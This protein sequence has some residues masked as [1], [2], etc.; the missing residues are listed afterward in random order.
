MTTPHRGLCRPGGRPGLFECH[1]HFMVDGDFSAKT[2]LESP[3]SPAFFQAAERMAH[4][5]DVGVL[6]AP[7]SIHPKTVER[8]A[9]PTPER[10][11][12]SQIGG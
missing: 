3:F 1:V 10:L 7:K 11:D 4:I 12:N 5:L 6:G 9:P 2:H 8:G